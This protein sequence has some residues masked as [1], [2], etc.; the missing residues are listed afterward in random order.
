LATV[1]STGAPAASRGLF[2]DGYAGLDL[3]WRET[4]VDQ[5]GEDSTLPM[6]FGKTSP[7]SPWGKA[8]SIPAGRSAPPKR[9]GA[10]DMPA[11]I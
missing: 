2:L 8:A 7:S 11:S 10:T 3:N 9:A 1:N 5:I 6:P 4:A